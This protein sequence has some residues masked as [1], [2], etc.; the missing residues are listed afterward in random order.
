MNLK[1]I[2]RVAENAK[3]LNFDMVVRDSIEQTKST[4]VSLNRQNLLQ[5]FKVDGSLIGKYASIPYAAKKFNQDGQAGFG[6]VNL[7][8]TGAWSQGIGVIVNSKSFTSL[9]DDI[10]SPKLELDYGN[11]ILGL[12]DSKKP[13]YIE[14]LA[15]VILEKTKTALFGL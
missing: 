4:I 15:P 2:H 8:L 11:T 14:V 10:K 9:S 13:N 5:G 6:N 7:Y 12:P 1:D 3:K